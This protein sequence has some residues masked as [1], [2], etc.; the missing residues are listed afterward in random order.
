[1]IGNRFRRQLK[2]M[3]GRLPFNLTYP[4]QLTFRFGERDLPNSLGDG[5]EISLAQ[6]QFLIAD[7]VQKTGENPVHVWAMENGAS[8]KVAQ[9]LRFAH[10]LDCFTLVMV[11]GEGF[12]KESVLQ[13]L[14]S[15]VDE[16][17][18]LFGGV[19]Q[20]VHQEVT[21]LDVDQT[22]QTLQWFLNA[23][24]ES[25]DEFR[26][27]ICI[28]VPWIYEAPKE[29]SAIRNWGQ[30]LGVDKI[31][32]LLPYYGAELASETIPNHPKLSSLLAKAL[33]GF[34]REEKSPKLPGWRKQVPGFCPIGNTR[35][36]I[37]AKGQVCS[38]PFKAPVT[39]ERE[40]MSALWQK[41]SAH[42]G[43]ILR[44]KQMCWHPELQFVRLQ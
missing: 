32:V 4:Q 43:E 23:R 18:F 11:N 1:M 29:M 15:G 35:L 42:R 20:Q 12:D 44:C 28:G 17:W 41:L 25:R 33:H 30:E 9:I 40:D 27:K 22:T 36:E 31:Q 5:S 16:I 8:E 26:S 6:V 19:S 21:G 2:R 3:V 34:E 38:C 13:L 14:R 37:G 39:W 24:A 7:F 10:R